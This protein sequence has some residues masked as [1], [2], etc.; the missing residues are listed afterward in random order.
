LRF[1]S[2]FGHYPASTSVW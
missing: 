1:C 2:C